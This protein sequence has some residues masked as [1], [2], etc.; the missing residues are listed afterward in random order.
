VGHR[1]TRSA[2]QV[3][4]CPVREAE[5]DAEAEAEANAEAN[6]LHGI[7]EERTQ[8]RALEKGGLRYVRPQAASQT[9]AITPRSSGGTK[10]GEQA[11]EF[12]GGKSG[13]REPLHD[14]PQPRNTVRLS[15]RW[16]AACAHSPLWR[17]S[18]TEHGGRT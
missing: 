9:I 17:G 11:P 1:S 12:A 2:E 14:A 8:L 16:S 4:H 3:Q 18:H 6:A 13:S 15:R 5:A 10:P 7:D